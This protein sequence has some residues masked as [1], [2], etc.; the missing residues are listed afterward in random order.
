[1]S[2]GAIAERTARLF[3]KSQ[4]KQT[5]CCGLQKGEDVEGCT[6]MRWRIDMGPLVASK[7][8][9]RQM[10]WLFNKH[11]GDNVGLYGQIHN[12]I[13]E[14]I[15]YG[16][17]RKPTARAHNQLTLFSNTRSGLWRSDVEGVRGANG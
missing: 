5:C 14:A 12:T 4:A 8:Q 13:Q 16:I 15:Q 10:A 7:W 11:D 9:E 6:D 3:L 17:V 2:S 1:M